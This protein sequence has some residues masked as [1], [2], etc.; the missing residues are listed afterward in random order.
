MSRAEYS[1]PDQTH[2]NDAVAADF[3]IRYHRTNSNDTGSEA[4]KQTALLRPQQQTCF[5]LVAMVAAVMN[6]G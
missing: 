2:T 5:E 6:C 4:V 3:R 1:P